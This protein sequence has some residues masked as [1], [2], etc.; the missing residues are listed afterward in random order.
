MIVALFD[1]EVRSRYKHDH[2]Y[3]GDDN[4]EHG[5]LV[6][7]HAMKHVILTVVWDERRVG[8]ETAQFCLA[9][10]VTMFVFHACTT[11]CT[12]GALSQSRT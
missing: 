5:Y 9:A 7:T 10:P 4:D 1:T 12:F 3:Q 6:T 11:C 8:V 2:E